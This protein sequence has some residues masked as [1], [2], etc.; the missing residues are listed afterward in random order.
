MAALL[1]QKEEVLKIELTKHGRKLLGQGIFQ[2]EFYLFFDDNVIYDDKYLSLNEIQNN[3]QDRILT[4]TLPITAL[5]LLEEIEIAP[6]GRS[7]T[8]SDYAPSWEVRV[9]NGL[10]DYNENSSSY[11]K[12]TFDVTDLTYQLSLEKKNVS[13]LPNFNFSTFEI[14]DGRIISVKDDYLLLEISEENVT[15]DSENFQLE[16][17][18]FEE[19]MPGIEKKLN[20]VGRQNNIID[21]ILYDDEE[22]PSRFGQI[23][24]NNSDAQFFL[25]VLVDDEIDRAI[26]TKA[27]RDVQ[28]QVKPT[29][30]STFEGPA[31]EDC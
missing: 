6:L 29:Y 18:L 14:E 2:P 11:Y 25:D 23:N 15:D 9:L 30:T 10:V 12:K 20:F 28:E 24:L 27:V 13:K 22:L 8:D 26:I 21:G 17:S 19:T 3:S 16:L 7:N 1:D 31:K 4:K 5:N